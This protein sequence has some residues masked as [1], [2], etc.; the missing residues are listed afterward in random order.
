MPNRS[1]LPSK[2]KFRAGI[3]LSAFEVP[4]PTFR[5]WI[6]RDGL[7]LSGGYCLLDGI[8]LGLLRD[9]ADGFQI[10]QAR[11]VVIV[12]EADPALRQAAALFD[13]EHW[14][15]RDDWPV[16]HVPVRGQAVEW[17]SREDDQTLGSLREPKL[18]VPL[19]GVARRSFLAVGRALERAAR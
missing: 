1:D 14:S 7:Q 12:R 16:L 9:L 5:T 15:R 19:K 17:F 4:S 6:D 18:I 10:R 3:L 2:W 13:D 11:A 8:R